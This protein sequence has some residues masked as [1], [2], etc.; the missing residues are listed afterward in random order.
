MRAL[1]P[2]HVFWGGV[3]QTTPVH[4]SGAHAAFAQPKVQV[5]SVCG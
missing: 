1:P 2:L 5:A 4:G 3:L